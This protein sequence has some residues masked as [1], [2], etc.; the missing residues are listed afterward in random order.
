MQRRVRDHTVDNASGSR[1]RLS[2]RCLGWAG[3]R[4]HSGSESRWREP[5][6]GGP[7]SWMEWP[8]CY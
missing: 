1:V 3:A 4:G 2:V 7:R 8:S 5:C 6:G